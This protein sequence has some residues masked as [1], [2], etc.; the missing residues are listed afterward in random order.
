MAELNETKGRR[1]AAPTWLTALVGALLLLVVA[2]FLL[3][4]SAQI[5]SA[6]AAADPNMQSAAVTAT[7][8]PAPPA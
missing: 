2:I 3:G 6:D 4:A 8:D 1:E 7:A 5:P